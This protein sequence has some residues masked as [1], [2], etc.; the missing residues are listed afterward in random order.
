MSRDFLIEF[1]SEEDLLK[2]EQVLNKVKSKNG[3]LIFNEVNNRGKDL[4]VSLTFSDDIKDNFSIY[5]HEVEF[6]GFKDDVSFV[7]IKNGHHDS[8]GYYLDSSRKNKDLNEI[9]VLK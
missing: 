4:F 8:L 7:A 2:V 6:K 9:L 1:E 3:D 5:I